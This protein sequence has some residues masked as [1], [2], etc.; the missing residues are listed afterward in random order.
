MDK[1]DRWQKGKKGR[2]HKKEGRRKEI[3]EEEEEGPDSSVCVT[4]FSVPYL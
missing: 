4:R 2:N 1:K 3:K